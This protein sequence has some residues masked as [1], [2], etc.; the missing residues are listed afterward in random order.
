MSH[1]SEVLWL[2]VS[3]ALKRFNRPLLKHL[4]QQ[5]AI[6]QWEYLQT[7]DEPMSFD[8]A[9]TLLHDHLKHSDRP[10]HLLGHGTSG[11]LG[12]LYARRHPERVRSLILLAV[13]GYP[14]VDW[15][16]HYYA[17]LQFLPCS[18]QVLLVQTVHNLFGSQSR[19]II[20]SLM[21]VLEQDLSTSLSPHTLYQRISFFPG[22]VPVPLMVCGGQDDIV[23][24]SNLL[25]GW[26]PW[27]KQCDRL[28]Q[29]PQG[30]Y[31]FHYSHPKQVS[32]NITDFWD[33]LQHPQPSIELSDSVNISV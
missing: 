27:L 30:R 25:Q 32:Q 9:L 22:G 14:A 7:A 1:R 20:R 15:Q 8:V 11:L 16:A 26:Q 19:P 6:A 29:C 28:W 10:V 4:S 17:Q 12:L 21:K 24:D 31:F 2:N 33:T 18:R 13:G 5:I 23:V 3:P